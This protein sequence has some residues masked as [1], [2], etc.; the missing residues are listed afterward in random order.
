MY[1]NAA[2]QDATSIDKE[3][4]QKIYKEWP[5]HFHNA[6]GI[7]VAPAHESEYYN[8]IVF[9]GMGGSATACD[10][11]NDL[12]KASSNIPSLVLRA[13]AMPYFVGE[14][15]IAVV[16]SVSGNTEEALAMAKAAYEK[17]AE[18]ISIS[19]GGK[20]QEL[21]AKLNLAH[22]EIPK[23]SVPRA[24]L[25]YI[26]MPGLKIINP[27][28]KESIANDIATMHLTL[29]KIRKDVSTDAS[30][31]F[32]IAGKI[33]D[34]LD[35]GF[36]FCFISPNLLSAGIRFKNSLNENA[37]M[38]CLTESIMEA[39]HNEIVPFTFNN[40]LKPRVLFVRWINDSQLVSNRFNKTKTFF[41]RIGQPFF[42]INVYNASLV[43]AIISTIYILDYV[44]IHAALLRKIDPSPTPAIDILKQM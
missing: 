10:I 15:T 25:P 21:S 29:D 20:L 32:N 7:D 6:A 40:N 8:S 33:A 12:M 19:A 26:M 42:E 9:C 18:V 1:V 28:M 37:K 24:S 31:S 36:I 43:N 23:L 34:F 30:A 22:V 3:N 5:E 27:L 16:I 38:H 41:D 4:M 11:L 39:S 14:H 44:S 13:Q 17:K 2:V 35:S